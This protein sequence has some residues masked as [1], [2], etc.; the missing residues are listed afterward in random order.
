[1]VIGPIIGNIRISQETHH[2]HCW[3]LPPKTASR[4]PSA[5]LIAKCKPAH[6]HILDNRF[7]AVVNDPPCGSKFTRANSCGLKKTISNDLFAQVLHLALGSFSDVANRY[8]AF[9]WHSN[10]VTPL[11]WISVHLSSPWSLLPSR[12]CAGSE[13]SSEPIILLDEEPGSAGS[14]EPSSRSALT[15]IA[16]GCV[17][18]VSLFLLGAIALSKRSFRAGDPGD[19]ISHRIQNARMKSVL[20]P[21]RRTPCSSIG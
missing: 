19:E 11:L 14:G 18:G 21:R 4:C 2:R 10:S 20:L 6:G 7:A 13:P 16:I 12:Q 17:A 8:T 9:R 5:V 1:M 15:G 3:F